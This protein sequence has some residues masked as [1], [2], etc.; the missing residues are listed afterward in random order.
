MKLKFRQGIIRCRIDNLTHQP[1]FLQYNSQS[2]CVNINI[3]NQVD[4]AVA[5]AHGTSDY[6]LEERLFRNNAWGTFQWQ[7]HWGPEPGSYIYYLYW[8]VHLATGEVTRFYTPKVPSYGPTA[9]AYPQY[10]EHW[11]DTTTG[12]MNNWNGSDWV[13]VIR[14]F[15]GTYN[16]VTHAVT[17]FPLGSHVG[18]TY[19]YTLTAE[20]NAGYILYGMDQKGIRNAGG[21]FLTSESPV[22]MN[23]GAYTSPIKLESASTLSIA[24]EPIPEYWLIRSS[25]D[26]QVSL[27][28]NDFPHRAAIGLAETS[29]ITGQEIKFISSGIVY[30]DGWSWDISNPDNLDLYCGQ[31]GELTQGIP[32]DGDIVQRIGTILSKT[33][34]SLNIDV[35][36]KNS[37]GSGSGGGAG[38]SDISFPVVQVNHGFSVGNAIYFDGFMWK[39]AKSD[40]P[41]TLGLV[42]VKNIIDANNFIGVQAGIITGLTNLVPGDYYFVSDVNAGALTNVEPTDINSYSNPLLQALTTSTGLVLPFRPSQMMSVMTGPTGPTGPGGGGG[43]GGVPFVFTQSTPLD[44]WNINH[45]RGSSDYVVSVFNASGSYVIP[46]SIVTVDDDNITITFVHPQDGK[47]VLAFSSSNNSGYT[48]NQVVAANVW[49]ITHNLGYYPS[50][51]IVDTL[52]NVVETNI[53][54][55]SNMVVEVTFDTAFAGTAYLR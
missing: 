39:L 4:L 16:P 47:A 52:G 49:T 11:F 40:S 48:F 33:S 20:V 6:L 1:D 10:D 26:N 27:A 36:S 50:V 46:E 15:A 34:I 21:G 7:P 35:Y 38:G 42:L 2:Q 5:F 9:P 54:Y 17:H 25:G 29:A 53:Q 14:V 19:P 24:A 12:Y 8:N 13:S 37:G 41:F 55:I 23:M 43:G 3:F 32:P 51:T 18:I 22:M 45:A 44:T 30:Y 31:N 28:S